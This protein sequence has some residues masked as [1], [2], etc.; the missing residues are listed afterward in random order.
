MTTINRLIVD[1]SHYNGT[2]DFDKMWAAGIRGVIH[3]ASESNS[4]TDDKYAARRKEAK[5]V[6]MLWGAYHFG[7]GST[8]D[9]QI[10]RFLEAA[11]P[12]ENTGLF[13]DW[14][15]ASMST[16]Q[17]K[18]FMMKVDEKMGRRTGL[19]SYVPFFKEHLNGVIDSWWGQR[20]IWVAAYPS[21]IKEPTGLPLCLGEHYWLWQYSDGQAGP[22]PH[23]C[24]GITGLVDSNH[25]PGTE[26]DLFSYWN[27]WMTSGNVPSLS[28]PVLPPI[29]G[30]LT[31]ST[32]VRRRFV[33][34]VVR[35]IVLGGHLGQRQVNQIDVVLDNWL[36]ISTPQL[37]FFNVVR[38]MTPEGKLTEVHVNSLN[39]A[40]EKWIKPEAASIEM[41]KPQLE[42]LTSEPGP[43]AG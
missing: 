4:Y 26:A 25:Y 1:L 10:K 21:S 40:L 36:N 33:F 37:L 42:V 32:V 35:S 18:D 12:D 15:A 16:A 19:Y 39:N 8:V 30:A 34:D 41:E 17:A 6:G 2:T 22:Q 14:E 31:E 11:Q 7:R 24:D 5:R 29:D 28:I 38:D 43:V 13:L 9:S 20:P 3:K 23:T 27:R